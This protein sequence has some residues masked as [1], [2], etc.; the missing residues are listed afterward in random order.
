MEITRSIISSIFKMA[1]SPL[2]Y[3]LIG[4]KIGVS[5][6][7]VELYIDMLRNINILDIA[8]FKEGEM[9]I[10]RKEK[11]F[12]FINP[13]LVKTLSLY[14]ATDYLE[15]ALYE[16]IVQSHLMRRYGEV[17][18]Y[19]NRYEIDCIADDLKIEVKIGKPYRRYPRN[20]FTLDRDN[21]P[22][23]LAAI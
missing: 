16:W 23:F 14:L 20:T 3:S 21:L 15:S 18:Y 22:Y 7:T 5:Y 10:W 6:K 1:P 4:R 12:F 9:V 11:K 2:S 8:Y 17:Y 19:R 13:Y